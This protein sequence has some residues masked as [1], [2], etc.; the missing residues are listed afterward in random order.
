MN[1]KKKRPWDLNRLALDLARE[2]IEEA[3]GGHDPS[4]CRG[5]SENQI[6]QKKAEHGYPD[7]GNSEDVIVPPHF[8]KIVKS[9]VRGDS[10]ARTAVEARITTDVAARKVVDIGSRSAL[11]HD[12]LVR[13]L[14]VQ[15]VVIHTHWAFSYGLRSRY[16]FPDGA[17]AAT[18]DLWLWIAS[19]P[20]TGFIM[21]W[22]TGCRDCEAAEKFV[23][24]TLARIDHPMEIRPEGK[25]LALITAA[26]PK[27]QSVIDRKM[28]VGAFGRPGASA[29]GLICRI[30]AEDDLAAFRQTEEL[31]TDLVYGLSKRITNLQ[32]AI[33]LHLIYAN[34][35]RAPRSGGA[36]PAVANQIA[37]A[38]LTL[39]RLCAELV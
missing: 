9:L 25:R 13:N 6:M 34:F 27:A 24:D 31:S 18:A 30:G 5:N 37:G 22:A 36:V 28:L 10:V 17:G 33:S 38:P 7:P 32:S 16:L 14:T 35:V 8:A 1:I 26:E 23:T 4:T 15:K 12:R 19:D 21:N 2:A 39:E 3:H 29:N 20:S 11:L